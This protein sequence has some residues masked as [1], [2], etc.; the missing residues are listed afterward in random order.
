VLLRGFVGDELRGQ[1][2]AELWF[3]PVTTLSTKAEI[4]EA[5]CGEPGSIRPMNAV[6][7]RS[8]AMRESSRFGSALS[9][10]ASAPAS[11]AAC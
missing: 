3:V 10:V 8:V 2:L 11:A 9:S 5:S 1:E 6:S 4:C 7:V